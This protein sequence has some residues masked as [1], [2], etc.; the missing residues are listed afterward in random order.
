M[1]KK[2][3]GIFLMSTSALFIIAC[4]FFLYFYSPQKNQNIETMTVTL[5]IQ[6]KQAA[7]TTDC[8]VTLPV[9]RA[10]PKTEGIADASLK[11]LFEEELASYASY[12]SVTIANGVARVN[13]RN[14]GDP[15]GYT[16]SGLSSCEAG[17]LMSVL[18]DTLTQYGE[19]EF[20]EIYTEAGKI[21]F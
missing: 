14:N 2:K 18:N 1:T 9:E 20:V 13:L 16:L 4:A 3:K 8:T 12:E 7:A 15:N 19:V 10:V 17:H 5:Y 6:D 21:E 11:I